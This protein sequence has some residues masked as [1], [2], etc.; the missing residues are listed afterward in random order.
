MAKP[1]TKREAKRIG[2]MIGV[3]WKRV[4]LEQFR[5]GLAIEM[6]HGRGRRTNVTHGD[7]LLTGRIALAHLLEIPDYYDRLERMEREAKREMRLSRAASR[8]CPSA[9]SRA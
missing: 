5:R 8:G 9:R 6:E 7:V 3:S 1:F 4:D 2:D